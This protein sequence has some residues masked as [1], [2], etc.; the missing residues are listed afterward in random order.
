MTAK[1]FKNVEK[2]HVV[3]A[4]KIIDRDGVPGNRGGKSFRLRYRKTDYP[5][6]YTLALAWAVANKMREK[7]KYVP[8]NS[9]MFE[10]GE[11][12]NSLLRSLGFKIK[13]GAPKSRAGVAKRPKDFYGVHKFTPPE[14]W[15]VSYFAT[16]D[17]NVIL[18]VGFQRKLKDDFRVIKV[19]AE[20]TNA[21]KGLGNLV[22][23]EKMGD[24]TTEDDYAHGEGDAILGQ[25]LAKHDVGVELFLEVVPVGP[26]RYGVYRADDEGVLSNAD[27]FVTLEGAWSFFWNHVKD[28]QRKA[29]KKV[30]KNRAA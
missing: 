18:P 12:T 23:A 26:Y 19:L 17:K 27:Y 13:E 30:R 25:A 6:K 22:I 3:K 1:L 20:N 14:G 7:G 10:G 29:R 24:L 9:S 16:E 15:E 11:Q 4:M 8:L 2:K 5:P 28:A 21:G